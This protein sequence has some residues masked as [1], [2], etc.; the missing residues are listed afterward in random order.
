MFEDL[1]LSLFSPKKDEC[2][3]C[4]GY[5][6]KNIDNIQYTEHITRKEQARKEKEEDKNSNNKVFT[7]DLQSVLLCPKS[8]VSALYYRTKLIVHNFTIFNLHTKDGYCFLWHEGEGSL[9]LIA[10]HL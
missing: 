10:F 2:D 7:M 8:N 4:V 5:K 6:T 9:V 1:N 3:I